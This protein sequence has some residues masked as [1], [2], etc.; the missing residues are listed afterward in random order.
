MDIFIA[1]IIC[2]WG[3]EKEEIKIKK[4]IQI[5]AMVTCMWKMIKRDG[6]A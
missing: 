1:A 4:E 2:A 6:A 5:N 3:K